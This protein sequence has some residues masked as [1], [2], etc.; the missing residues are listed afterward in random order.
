MSNPPIPGTG[1]GSRPTTE[2]G[3]DNLGAGESFSGHKNEAGE[4]VSRP[5]P[6]ERMQARRKSAEAARQDDSA[7]FGLTEDLTP[8]PNPEPGSPDA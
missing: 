4:D 8:V 1:D 5:A 2:G 6:Q 3:V 7:A